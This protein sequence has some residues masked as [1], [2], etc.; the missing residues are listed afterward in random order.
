M[1]PEIVILGGN[2]DKIP[3]HFEETEIPILSD[4]FYAD[5]NDDMLPDLILAR[6]PASTTTNMSAICQMAI[7]Y[8]SYPG[9]WKKNV[10]F[11]AHQDQKYITCKKHIAE[12]IGD[13]FTLDEEYPPESTRNDVISRIN[14]GIVFI[15]YRGHG[16]EYQWM[17]DNGLTTDY[18]PKLDNAEKP[19]QIFS[20]A[21]KNNKLDAY[22]ECFGA[23][24][25]SNQKS[26]NFLGASRD[27][28]TAVNDMFDNY[29]WEGIINQNL[30]TAGDI[31]NWA[32]INLY[33]HYPK[34]DDK[35]DNDGNNIDAVIHNIKVY[36]MLGDPAVYYA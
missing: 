21:C 7:Q 35:N 36:L 22:D 8:S 12:Q 4:F 5:L 17:A 11:I 28:Y 14:K 20:I 3:S 33:K 27:S 26:I 18:I 15:N 1:P 34:S 31:Y 9:D 25:I 32:T 30:K 29:L 24:W 13:T 19:P 2:I 10:L 23:C 6:F 16:N